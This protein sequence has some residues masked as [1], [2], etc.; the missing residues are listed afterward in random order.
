MKRI[1]V[2]FLIAAISIITATPALSVDELFL[3]GVIKKIDM[4][5]GLITV[6]V[7]S[8]SC[9]GLRTF[10]I[11]NLSTY[12]LA[13]NEHIYFTINSSSCLKDTVHTIIDFSGGK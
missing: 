13:T 10:K 7:K 4:L 9:I 11:N 2:F 8:K 5:Q 12:S 1:F 6:D 3:A